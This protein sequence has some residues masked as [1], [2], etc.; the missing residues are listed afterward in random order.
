[1]AAEAGIESF[2][3]DEAAHAAYRFF[4]SDLCDWYLELI[5][6]ILRGERAD[7]TNGTTGEPGAATL[8]SERLHRPELLPETRATLAYVL[9]GSLRLLHPMMPFITEELWQRVPKPRS[10]RAS[11]AFGPFPTAEAER[12]SA[13]VEVDARMELLKAVVSAART[14][15]SEHGVDKWASMPVRIRCGSPEVLAFLREHAE[16]VRVLVRTA[17][18]PVFEGM[19]GGREVGSTVSVVPSPEGPIDVLV[20]LK[21]LVEPQAERARIE[22]ELKKVDK[23]LAAIDK[24]LRS[25][26]FVDRAPAEIVE[27]AEAQRASMLEAK[28]RLD[29]ARRLAEEL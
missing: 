13:D 17:G 29:A 18:D 8:R 24:K 16:A 7:G 19:G 23:E 1:M 28:G 12:S 3:I 14:V 10:R 21:G 26:G 27:E 20:S 25:P 15:R 2:R 6:P 9:E 11:V 4:W 22:R 5:K